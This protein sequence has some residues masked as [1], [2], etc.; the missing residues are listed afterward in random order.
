MNVLVLN[1]T[2]D[3]YGASRILVSAVRMLVKHG[4]HPIVVLT[5]DGPLAGVMREAGAEVVFIR[6]GILRRKYKNIP[7][8]ANRLQVMRKAYFALKKLIG[9]RNISVVYSNTTAVLVGAFAARSMGIRHIWHVQEIIE[10]PKWLQRILGNLLNRYCDAVVVVS[11]AVKQS[12]AK[13]VA[14][15]KLHLI[16]SS[17]DFSPY[18]G[19]TD[20][21]RK[22]LG[23]ANDIVLIGMVGRV[24]HWKGQDYFL[25]IAGKLTNEYANIRFVMIGD[26]FPGYE[27]L[28][29]SLAKIR[30]EEGLDGFVYDLGYRTDVPDLMA[31]FDI[32]V[33]PSVLPDPFPTVVLEAMAAAK[34][35]VAT[36]HGG[37]TEMVEDGITGVHIPVNDPGKAAKIIGPLIL[38]AGY[39]KK[40]GEAARRKV[41]SEYSLEA[42]ENKLIK[43]FE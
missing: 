14:P 39:R 9:E 41:L 35:V 25:R 20:K 43:I 23:V 33:L 13:F 30:K 15:D 36:F 21:L 12:W 17:I 4:H 34:P 11:T 40:A 31:G 5:E 37:A 1:S 16:Y 32:M 42:F 27:Y 8:L 38:D 2:S 26:V 29:D 18:L 3:L 22:E 7:G 28:Y 24:H 19:A 6:L 10:D